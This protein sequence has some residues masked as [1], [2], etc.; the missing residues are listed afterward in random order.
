MLNAKV[1]GGALFYAIAISV[2]I[3]MAVTSLLLCSDLNSRLLLRDKISFCVINNAESGVVAALDYPEHGEYFNDLFAMHKD[4]VHVILKPWG[5]YDLCIAEAGTGDFKAVKCAVIGNKC[6]IQED[7]AIWLADRDHPLHVCGNT[8]ISGNAFLPSS[9][10]E[11]AYIEGSSYTGSQLVYGNVF[12]SSRN[13]ESI[14]DKMK[15]RLEYIIHPASEDSIVTEYYPEPFDTIV[16]N[17]S[18]ICIAFNLS[19]PLN[20]K[21]V[22]LHDNIKI[23]SNN[24][25]T[26]DQCNLKNVQIIAPEI[27]VRPGTYT[28]VQFVATDS[29]VIDSAVSIGYP[30]ALVLVSTKSSKTTTSITLKRNVNFTG[31][32]IAFREQSDYRKQTHIS[33]ES[34]VILYGR[35]FSSNTVDH[36]GKL[37]GSLTCSSLS[38]KTSSAQY[39]NHL[40]NAIIDNTSMSR[41]YVSSCFFNNQSGKRGIATWLN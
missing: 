21:N 24:R 36:K 10:I 33:I 13:F 5:V 35:I 38:L 1:Q 4:S 28:G 29:L 19:R 39:S 18:K 20:L 8:R 26:I 14:A 25:I 3:A 9:G 6:D 27:I 40:L 37:C 16:G 31:D 22:V 23:I 17:F 41:S 34:E 32:I 30:S 12:P 2:V 15:N 7:Y 11:R